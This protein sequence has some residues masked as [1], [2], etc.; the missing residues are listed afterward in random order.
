MRLYKNAVLGG[1][2]CS[3]NCVSLRLETK[4]QNY[5]AVD[6]GI[7][8]GPQPRRTFGELR[9]LPEISWDL[10]AHKGPPIGA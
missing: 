9:A 7:G 10:I 2:G 6:R 8:E 5:L 1:Q 4:T 3:A